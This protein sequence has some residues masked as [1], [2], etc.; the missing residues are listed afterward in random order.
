MDEDKET[1]MAK[2]A[3]KTPKI[4]IDH[5][6]PAPRPRMKFENYPFASMKVGD[7]IL[8]TTASK[9]AVLNAT[10]RARATY[11]GKYVVREVKGGVRAWRIQ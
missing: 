10:V 2:E 4:A 6:V 1:D 8:V 11:G 9:K 3:P 7:S 5:D